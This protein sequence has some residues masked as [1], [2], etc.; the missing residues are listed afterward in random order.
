MKTNKS[1]RLPSIIIGGIAL[2]M[3]ATSVM[4]DAAL[5]YKLALA[6][7]GKTYQVWM[8]PAAT[9]KPDISLTGQVTVKVPNK[10]GFTATNIKSAVEGSNWVEA[11][12]VDAPKEDAS[13]DYISFSFVGLQGTSARNYA[14]EAGKE[15]MVF[16]FENK[17]GCVD[18]VS[19][20]ANDDPFNASPNS[21]NTNPGN[22][23]TNL[24][25]GAVSENHYKGNY[26][27]A[28]ACK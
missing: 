20:M 15:L 17:N 27:E 18:G 2:F 12:R 8:K 24:G 13:S 28:I 4:A 25:W 9:P 10:A 22:Q 14:W 16:S 3:S 26:G 7:D 5:E 21:A 1:F 23:F 19:L 11:S 6:E